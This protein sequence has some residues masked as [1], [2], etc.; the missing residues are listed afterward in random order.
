SSE[1]GVGTRKRDYL[2][3]SRTDAD[4]AAMRAL[5]AAFDPDG[6]LNPAVLFD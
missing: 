5:K 2:T 1:H 4:I 3:M 6:C